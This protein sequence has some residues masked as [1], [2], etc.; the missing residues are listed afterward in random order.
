MFNVTKNLNFST[1]N[2]YYQIANWLAET[3]ETKIGP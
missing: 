1:R 3:V 2:R